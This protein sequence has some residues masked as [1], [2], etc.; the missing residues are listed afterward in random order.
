MKKRLFFLLA[1]TVALVIGLQIPALAA[2]EGSWMGPVVD[3]LRDPP[4]YYAQSGDTPYWDSTVNCYGDVLDG[5]AEEIYEELERRFAAHVA[6]TEEIPLETV[7]FQSGP[8]QTWVLEDIVSKKCASES[9]RNAWVDEVG[10]VAYDA[11][12]AFVYDHP[13]YFWVREHFGVGTA[14]VGNRASVN[15]Y[16]IA[17]K[18]F[19]DLE[20]QQAAIDE[21]VAYL[22]AA[23]EGLT[24]A[25]KV[26]WWDNWLAANN[27][28]KSAALAKDYIDSDATP[29]SIVGSLL[30][31]YQPV[32]EG[33]AKA[34]QLLCH[35]A[36]IIC[37]QQSG[38]ANG[39]GHMWAVVKLDG[40]WYFCD[41][42]WDDP[43]TDGSSW[44]YSI[45]EYLL[46]YQPSSHGSQYYPTLGL[47]QVT[48]ASYGAPMSAAFGWSTDDST[49]VGYEIGS[50]G[51]M[52]IA[53]YDDGGRFLAMGACD[54]MVWDWNKRIYL[55]PHFSDEV[56][57]EAA[58]AVRFQLKDTVNWAPSGAAAPIR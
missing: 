16:Y 7:K 15:V 27:R 29:W 25:Q 33:Y 18:G 44:E 40:K 57:R 9:E 46:T 1:L 31:D 22:T 41:P 36:G 13:E 28:Y 4:V 49:P 58:S 24:D 51:T 5:I 55:A 43:G 8:Q 11:L 56:L 52:L 50:G 42:T 34:L 37:V 23:V 30:P 6:G 45:R 48:S 54:S 53:L 26:A 35:E 2:D 17:Q 20:E 39:G 38:I 14:W 12:R 10:S 32:C 21:T 19:D 3:A 47:P